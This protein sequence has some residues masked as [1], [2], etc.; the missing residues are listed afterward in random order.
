MSKH[1]LTH[2]RRNFLRNSSAL[3]ALAILPG[4]A[5]PIAIGAPPPTA[6]PPDNPLLEGVKL[7]RH[8]PHH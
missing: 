6:L 2:S 7:R 4:S 5:P 3:T 1:E 8:Y